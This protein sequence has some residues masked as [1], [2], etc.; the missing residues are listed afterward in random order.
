MLNVDIG[1][2]KCG[3]LKCVLYIMVIDLGN[4]LE[5][6]YPERGRV[7]LTPT[8]NILLPLKLYVHIR[9]KCEIMRMYRGVTWSNKVMI[10]LK[11][12]NLNFVNFS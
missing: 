10:L 4:C 1:V 9:Q 6:I 12:V 5:E 11:G 8:I 2:R 3:F 7:V